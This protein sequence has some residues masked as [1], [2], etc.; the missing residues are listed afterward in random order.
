MGLQKRKMKSDFTLTLSSDQWP[1]PILPLAPSVS[2]SAFSLGGSSLNSRPPSVADSR[3][4]SPTF[5]DE[6][7]LGMTDSGPSVQSEPSGTNMIGNVGLKTLCS[8]H[9]CLSPRS[10]DHSPTTNLHIPFLHLI[11]LN[12]FLN[13][14]WLPFLLAPV[15]HHIVIVFA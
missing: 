14:I 15:F 5:D 13:D 2:G 11:P 10:C 4:F 7:D 9:Y 3:G 8:A 12:I 6:M 1:P